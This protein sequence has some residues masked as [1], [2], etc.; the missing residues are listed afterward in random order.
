MEF[1]QYIRKFAAGKDSTSMSS[2]RPAIGWV[3][4]ALQPAVSYCCERPLYPVAL[5][6]WT[7]IGNVLPFRAS[8]NLHFL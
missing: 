6:D 2:F 7:V 3:S 1:G 8:L 4:V 5:V